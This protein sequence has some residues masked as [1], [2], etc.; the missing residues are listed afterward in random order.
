MA[1][2]N[3]KSQQLGRYAIQKL[4]R[5]SS[6]KRA[7]IIAAALVIP[8]CAT[9]FGSLVLPV[10]HWLSRQ[11]ARHGKDGTMSMKDV[12]NLSDSKGWGAAPDFNPYA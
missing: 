11:S 8:L 4:I 2:L 5:P 1:L 6:T 12:K 9:G 3:R 7:Y 10:F